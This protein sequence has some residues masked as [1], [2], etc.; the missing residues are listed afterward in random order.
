VLI[1]LVGAGVAYL[2]YFNGQVVALRLGQSTLELPLALLLLGALALGA[3]FVLAVELLRN[4]ALS[5]RRWRSRRE[6]K[7]DR[8]LDRSRGEGTALLWAGDFENAARL[9]ARVVEQRPDDLEAVLDLA[10]AHEARGETETSRRVLETARAQRGPDARLLSQLG[11][12]AMRRGNAGAA[13]D[14]L[15]EAIG[16]APESPRLL[17]EYAGALAAEGRFGEAVDVARRRLSLEREPALRDEA[18]RA[19]LAVRYRAALALGETRASEEA[20]RKLVADAP[21]FLPPI[22]L[23]STRA[24]AGGDVRVA[25]RVLRDAIRRR[26]RGV[27]LERL[28]ALHSGTGRPEL[29]L[30]T[31]RDACAGNHFAGPRLMLARALVA[32]GKLEAADA[33]LTD[34]AKE[35]PRFARE[36][37]DIAPERDL[38]AGELALARGQEREAAKLLGRAASGTHR[39]FG[40]RCSHCSRCSGEWLDACACGEFGTYDWQVR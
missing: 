30:P 29:A 15:R 39:A 21:D 13:T 8:Q 12:L 33:E 27:L 4:G 7:R 11:H 28:A 24:R 34:L 25:E 10:R 17:A 22:L 14:A 26:P 3:G 31:L 20:L 2:Y 40:H 9:L 6:E 19:V 5:L 23:L 38:V 16:L 37:N 32:A 36:G 1:A 35:S 18:Q